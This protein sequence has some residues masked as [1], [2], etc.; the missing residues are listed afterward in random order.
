MKI[1]NANNNIENLHKKKNVE[2]K[3][4]IKKTI[5][6]PFEGENFSS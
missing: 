2:K 4:K 6:S 3:F 1:S 5:V